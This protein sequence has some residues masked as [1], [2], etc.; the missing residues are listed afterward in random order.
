MKKLQKLESDQF[1][2]E[3]PML[4]KNM[5]RW[6]DQEMKACQQPPLGRQV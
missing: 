1:Y 6:M 4:M 3:L 5:R 2:K